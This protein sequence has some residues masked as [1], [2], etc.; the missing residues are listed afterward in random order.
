MGKESTSIAW[1]FAQQYLI[2]TLAPV[3]EKAAE[4]KEWFEEN[5]VHLHVPEGATKKDGPS[6]GVTMVT[7]LLSLALDRPIRQKL[8]MTGEVGLNGAVMKIGGVK[9]K[10]MAARR[11][12]ATTLIFPADNQR[13]FEELAD[14]ITDGLEVHFVST[15]QQVY[16]IAFSGTIAPEYGA[17]FS[18]L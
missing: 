12:G 13:D 3:D 8:G 7:S 10:C 14:Y 16:D 9:E 4:R 15:Y 5:G 17:H 1:T 2:E 18:S 6:A 11:A